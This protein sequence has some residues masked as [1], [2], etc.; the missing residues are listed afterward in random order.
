M[1]WVIHPLIQ[2][3]LLSAVL[4]VCLYLFL[5][6]KREQAL[7][8]R[9]LRAELAQLRSS[10]DV[11]RIQVGHLERRLCTTEER[12]EEPAPSAVPLPGMNLTRRSQVLRMARRGDTP[13]AIAAELGI[14]VNEVELLLKVERILN[15]TPITQSPPTP[16]T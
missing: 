14:P 6:T 5:A 16:A 12:V 11:L 15:A 4:G 9:L 3:G 13:D 8:T 7:D 2:Y 10:F 1:E